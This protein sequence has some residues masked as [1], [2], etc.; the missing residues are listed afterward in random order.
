MDNKGQVDAGTSSSHTGWIIFG[1]VAMIIVIIIMSV[2]GMYNGL[3]SKDVA[4]T[5]N[6]G[7][8][9]TAYQRR[10]DLIPNYMAIVQGAM[11]FEKSTQTEIAQLRS[12][13][14][15]I[16][17]QV[18]SAKTPDELQSAENQMP[19]LVGRVN[20][21]VEAYPDLKSLTNFQ[22]FQDEL[23][24]TEN[25]IKFERDNYNTA[26][27]SYQVAVRSFPTNILAGMYGFSVDK[28]KMFQ[29]QAGAENAPKIVFNTTG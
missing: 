26:V 28:Y 4:V 1:V 8:V 29:S 27:Q 6:W 15:Q 21:V 11:S 9:E 22:A 14:G 25:R 10:A 2:A 24:G 20:V 17:Q 7:N 18:A 23:A 13:A 3:V 19:S 12:D 5:K 16:Q